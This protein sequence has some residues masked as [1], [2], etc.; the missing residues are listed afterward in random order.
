MQGGMRNEHRTLL[1]RTE[2]KRFLG[3]PRRRW[4]NYIKINFKDTELQ[5]MYWIILAQDRDRRVVVT[6]IINLWFP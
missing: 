4:K 6:T 3:R 5:D 2:R 1:G